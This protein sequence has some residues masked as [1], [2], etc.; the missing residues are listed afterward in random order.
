MVS[1]DD[2]ILAAISC[3]AWL[4]DKFHALGSSSKGG[5]CAPEFTFLPEILHR[6][7][8]FLE[9]LF[10]GAGV[11]D[12]GEFG[13][14]SVPRHEFFMRAA[15]SSKAIIVRPGISASSDKTRWSQQ[16]VGRQ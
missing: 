14:K 1:L 16:A 11:L 8:E 13:V 7:G 5:C 12:A 4:T 15:A 2:I 9:A 10:D 6:H 3:R